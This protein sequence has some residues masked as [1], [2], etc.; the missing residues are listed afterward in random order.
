MP[1]RNALKH[2]IYCQSNRGEEEE[3]DQNQMSKYLETFV[4]L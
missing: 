2:R 1:R 3:K 4:F